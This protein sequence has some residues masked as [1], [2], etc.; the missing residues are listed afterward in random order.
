[1]K[2]LPARNAPVAVARGPEAEVYRTDYPTHAEMLGQLP[3]RSRRYMVGV[4]VFEKM[5]MIGWMLDGISRNFKPSETRV[6]FYFDGC[7]DDSLLMFENLVWYYLTRRDCP[8]TSIVGPVQVYEGPAHNALIEE[9]MRTDSEFLIVPQDDQTF[10][11]SVIKT[12]E[13]IRANLKGKLGVIGGRDGFDFY[14]NTKAA[15][16]QREWPGGPPVNPPPNIRLENGAWTI[17]PFINT[18]PVVYNR[19]LVETIGMLDPRFRNYYHIEDYCYRARLAGFRN[20]VAGM[21]VVHVKFG[22]YGVS[23]VYDPGF[24]DADLALVREKVPNHP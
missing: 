23:N 16:T 22:R 11:G 19:H 1:M 17:H 21:P 6:V 12:L 4:P 24:V 10:D 18:G 3:S 14:E 8:V 13:N 20:V 7:K 9:F 15:G 5:D 2:T